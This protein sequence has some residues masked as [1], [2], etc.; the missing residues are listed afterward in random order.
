MLVGQFFLQRT[1]SQISNDYERT[2]PVPWWS[3]V[4]VAIRF[5]HHAL[6]RNERYL[7]NDTSNKKTVKDFSFQNVMIYALANYE[8]NFCNILYRLLSFC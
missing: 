6:S 3:R 1:V 7:Q 4:G 2:N 5:P 8:H